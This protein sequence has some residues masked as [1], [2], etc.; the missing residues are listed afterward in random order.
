MSKRSHSGAVKKTR[1]QKVDD[2]FEAEEIK[3]GEIQPVFKPILKGIK[4]AV[5]AKSVRSLYHVRTKS[6]GP[7]RFV[8]NVK[9]GSLTLIQTAENLLK[10]E[11]IQLRDLVL[12]NNALFN[13]ISGRIEV[14]SNYETRYE[15]LS[16][17]RRS[18]KFGVK[19]QKSV[20]FHFG[21][22]HKSLTD[23]KLIL[24]DINTVVSKSSPTST[25]KRMLN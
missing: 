10:D 3:T 5:D 25:T 22:Y 6:D 17:Q 14:L 20:Q 19:V 8:I 16:V 1:C 4:E 13:P 2:V 12:P 23:V 15:V 9:T 11:K 21:S 24:R 7:L 18:L